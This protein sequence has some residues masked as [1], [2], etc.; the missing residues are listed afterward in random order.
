MSGGVA[1]LDPVVPVLRRLTALS[2][3]C[4]A[5]GAAGCGGADKGKIT[6]AQ[7]TKLN[8]SV[9]RAEAAFE[10]GDCVQARTVAAAGADKVAALGG[11]VDDALRQNLIDGFN[12]LE[13]ELAANCDKPTA[14]PTAT[15][16]ATAT[17]TATPEPTD[18]PSATPKPTD[19]PT[20]TPTTTTE[21]TATPT[22]NDTGGT[23]PGEDPGA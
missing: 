5:L 3:A 23:D 4:L 2:T 14:T 13:K 9:D 21:P 22:P 17:E 20:A 7:A 10:K 1:S 11:D 8:R 12:H 19:T 16:T 6:T 18:T 15:A